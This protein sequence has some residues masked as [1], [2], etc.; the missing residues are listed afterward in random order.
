MRTDDNELI[1]RDFGGFYRRHL[2]MVI[3]WLM[4]QVR[5]A[6]LAADLSGEVFAAALV[7]RDRFD[8][9]RGPAKA[10]LLAIARNALVDSVRRGRVEDRARRAL[11]VATLELTDGDLARVEE[12][13][14]AAAA[15]PLALLD[16][17]PE[18]QRRAIEARVLD[19]LEYA[20]VA[21]RLQCSEVVAR[22]RVSRGLSALRERLEAPR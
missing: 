3:G 16:G 17:L 22:K 8:P 21:H 19:E 15:A 18:D 20:D 11:G 2:P 13:A 14:A 7:A 6:E 4:R 5:D 10:W 9:Q 12:M 1:A